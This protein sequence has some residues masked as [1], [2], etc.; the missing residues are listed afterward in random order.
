M[1]LFDYIYMIITG[2]VSLVAIITYIIIVVI[3]VSYN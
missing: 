2:G 3:Y 1:I